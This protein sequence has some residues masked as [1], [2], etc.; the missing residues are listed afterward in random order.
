MYRK[1]RL[2]SRRKKR[3]PHR[4]YFVGGKMKKRK[5]PLVEVRPSRISSDRMATMRSSCRRAT[6][7]FSR[8]EAKEV[9][10]NSSAL[11]AAERRGRHRGVTQRYILPPTHG[12]E[13]SRPRVHLDVLR[14]R[15]CHNRMGWHGLHPQKGGPSQGRQ[16]CTIS[17]AYP[18]Q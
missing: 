10:A 18:V 9:G 16:I 17:S 7:R 14:G 12:N 1:R 13:D 4:D 3:F 6:L 11:S 2:A 15:C 8:A 5:I